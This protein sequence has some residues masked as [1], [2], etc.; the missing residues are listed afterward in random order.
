MTPDLCHE[1]S[2]LLIYNMIRE[3]MNVEV[4][5]HSKMLNMF[6]YLFLELGTYDM[7]LL[8]LSSLSCLQH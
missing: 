2:S 8:I 7:Q 1:G 4:P 3:K 6:F 5:T